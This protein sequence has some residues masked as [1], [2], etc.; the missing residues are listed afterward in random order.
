MNERSFIMKT[1]QKDHIMETAL[2]L[3]AEKGYGS[4]SIA[5]IA[6]EAGVAQGLMYNYFTSKE[7]LLLAIL[8]T[9]FADVQASMSAYREKLPP[10][11]ALA[12]HVEST[13]ALV[14]ANKNFWRLFHAIK[15]QEAVQQFLDKD[16][17]KAR[18][19]IIGTLA[20]NFKTLGYAHPTEEA[21]LFFTLIDGL[22]VNHL[23]APKYFPL[24]SIKKILF[25][26]YKI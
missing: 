19:Y 11:K 1:N 20:Q 22:V 6:R 17:A 4:T 26:K 15:M 23:M 3:F 8:E 5:T 12:L 14:A 2:R 10:K 21:K 7:D 9:G 25:Q 16:Y 18:D 24:A 13:F